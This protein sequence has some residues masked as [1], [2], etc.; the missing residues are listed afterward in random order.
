MKKLTILLLLLT[1]TICGSFA[2]VV[3]LGV[4][5]SLPEIQKAVIA[6]SQF[7]D[8]TI[9]IAGTAA[10]TNNT[11]G[12]AQ[13]GFY[14]P[15]LV[16]G[17]D[18]YVDVSTT[19]VA[20]STFD[21]WIVQVGASTT[22]MAGQIN[23]FNKLLGIAP[24]NVSYASGTSTAP[25][26][27]AVATSI[28]AAGSDLVDATTGLARLASVQRNLK[29]I[30]TAANNLA[31]A[32]GYSKMPEGIGGISNV[33]QEYV[34]TS[35]LVLYLEP[36][37]YT[38]DA[39]AGTAG[40]TS[41]KQVDVNTFVADTAKIASTLTAYLNCLSYATAAALTTGTGGTGTSI[42]AL[43]TPVAFTHA[44]GTDLA[45]TTEFNTFNTLAKANMAD[46]AAAVNK[47]IVKTGI[48]AS[49][50]T[51]ANRTAYDLVVASMASAVALSGVTG[52]DSDG[53]SYTQ[54][55]ASTEAIERGI[56]LIT[57]QVNLV[58]D[59]YGVAR[60]ANASTLGYSTTL[61]LNPNVAYADGVDGATA[62]AISHTAAEA[63][64][65]QIQNNI[66][67]LYDKINVLS[68]LVTTSIPPKVAVQY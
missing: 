14:L 58:A 64:F 16:P 27:P 35:R 28:A 11:G 45:S 21:A 8:R 41:L 33:T 66:D 52:T 44:S 34:A 12:T 3:K 4:A 29:T 62:E 23:T 9:L 50:I 25:T 57:K 46:C 1:L 59:V 15:T 30:W 2:E 24:V 20:K 38:G 60:L 19:S 13:N 67:A 42:T 40:A 63:I 36:L 32:V 39:V 7:V 17:L 54:F 6:G 55:A 51:D 61:E 53:V 31:V 10:M 18:P 65:V 56:N 68:A 22:S 5:P 49:Y 43:N 26:I 48:N 47:L 37:N